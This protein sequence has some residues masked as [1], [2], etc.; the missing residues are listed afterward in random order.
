MYF[1]CVSEEVL[2]SSWKIQRMWSYKAYVGKMYKERKR[3]GRLENIMKCEKD[4]S[5]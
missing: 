4:G 2:E 3:R 5:K 1:I